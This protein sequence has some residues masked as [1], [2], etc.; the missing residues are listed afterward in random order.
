MKIHDIV[1]P[2]DF[3]ECSRAA[4]ERARG[5]AAQL[6][7]RLHLLHAV[8]PIPY[9]PEFGYGPEVLEDVE[10]RAALHLSR[11]A[12]E[13]RES[14]CEVTERIALGLAVD[15]ILRTA[16]EVDAQLVVM[17]TH[18][19]TGLKHAVLGSIAARTLR[20]APCPVWTCPS[21]KVEASAAVD[22]V[23]LPTD[24]SPHADHA[25]DVA[26]SLCG[27]LGAELDLIHVVHHPLPTYVEIAGRS[28][29][30]RQ[31]REAAERRLA[32]ARER[33]DSAGLGGA[34]EIR[35]GACAAEISACAERRGVD[36]IVL[37]TRGN[38]GFRRAFL[39]SVAE[40]VVR[41]APC[42]VLT[43]TQEQAAT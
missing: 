16:G 15:A 36:L 8:V 9:P 19:N 24:F 38:R 35:E 28:E 20:A 39:G 41:S 33:A 23:L 42:S 40:R 31:T 18:G 43:I 3:S 21:S 1:V 27:L 25:L 11:W 12:R 30:E 6:G 22:R 17:G 4:V 10:A 13:L 32:E 5:L 2:V 34:S 37:G 26:I 7:A 29:L 14:G